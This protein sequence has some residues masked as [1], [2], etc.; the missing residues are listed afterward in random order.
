M[1]HLKVL[2]QAEAFNDL[3]TIYRYLAST[4]QNRTIAKDFVRRIKSR[5]SKIGFTPYGGPARDYLE[6]GLRMVPFE[7]SA[8][9]LYKVEPECVLITNV[10][11]GGRDYEALFH[12][13]AGAEEATQNEQ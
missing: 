3:E 5:C 6:Q 10:F 7:H 13:V 8:V 12:G 9:I 2:Y 11:Y 1:R 4:T